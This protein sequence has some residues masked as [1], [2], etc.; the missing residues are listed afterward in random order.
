MVKWLKVLLIS[1]SL[2]LIPTIFTFSFASDLL[3]VKRVIDGDTLLL[4]NGE[5]VRLIGI[6]TPEVHESGKLY[7]DAERSQRDIETIRKLG[8]KSSAF[9][10]RL[11][12]GKR[13]RL[14]YDQA[15]T[16]I[17][18][19]DRYR[20]TLGYVYLEDGT[21]LNA[22][23][24]RQGYG[25]AY[26]KYPFKYADEFRKYEREAREKRRGLWGN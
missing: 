21:F 3:I 13:V 1:V 5:R 14:E 24:V 7:R 17:G 2:A 26:T 4:G 15:N 22:E 23:I 20:R 18:N 19:R 12:H 11:V 16:A 8:Q 25:V 6:D 9:V 10:T